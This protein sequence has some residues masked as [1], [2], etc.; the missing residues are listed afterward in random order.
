MSEDIK[1]LP[2]VLF[3]RLVIAH[4]EGDYAGVVTYQKRL[5]GIGWFVSRTPPEEPKP[6]RR[7]PRPASAKDGGQ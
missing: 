1:D 6:S 5:A 4:S 3:A 7:K 2:F